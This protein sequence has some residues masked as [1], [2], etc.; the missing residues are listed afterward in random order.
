MI[1]SCPVI[2]HACVISRDGYHNRY[3]ERYGE[4]TWEMMKT[5][6]SIVVERATKFVTKQDGK[7]MIYYEKIGRKEDKRIESYFNELRTTGHPFSSEA[8][9]KYSPLSPEEFSGRLSG[10]QGKTK[11][12]SELQVADLCLYPVARRKDQPNNRA[13]HAMKEKGLLVD[14]HLLPAELDTI[15]IKYFCFDT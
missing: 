8:A 13:Y 11:K 7:M 1:T 10:I 9:S 15:G 2:V 4:N 12:H 6:F 3:L 5:A 14:C